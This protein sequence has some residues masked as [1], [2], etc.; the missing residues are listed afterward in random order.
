M[1][2]DRAIA[3]RFA[4]LVYQGIAGAGR[5]DFITN[6]DFDGDWVG[7]NNWA[8]AED[9]KYPLKGYVYWAL[10]E[11]ET[12]YFIFYA[13]FHPRDWKGGEKK[14][15]VLS[16]TIREVAT[17]GRHVDQPPGIIGDLVLSHEND[18]EGCVVAVAKGP[19]VETSHVVFLETVAHNRYL[20]FAPEPDTPETLKL[21]LEGNHPLIYIEPK[22][23]G[24]H[25]YSGQGEK[26]PVP[27]K[28]PAPIETEKKK[29]AEKDTSL[30]GKGKDAVTKIGGFFGKA[31]NVTKV[32]DLV[33]KK[34]EQESGKDD[35]EE[36]ENVLIYRFTGKAED[37]Q[38]ETGS[39]GYDLLPLYD[40]F[41]KH[42]QEGRS[43]AYGESQDYGVRSIAVK[44]SSTLVVIKKETIGRLGSALR[45]KAGA[46]NKA[47]PPWG[48]F[49][50]TDRKRPL[51]EWFLD[52]A[53]TILRHLGKAKDWSTAYIHN[54]FLRIFR[55]Q[56][57]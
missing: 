47:R 18:L 55:G 5:F 12:H 48:W 19:T 45:G 9:E 1:D 36:P 25:G 40:T 41:W 22:G 34:E 31:R 42:A 46:P 21:I 44:I 23:H 7:D 8:N 16:G 4:P 50:M 33:S 49:D 11:T 37:P 26:K 24:V 2:A 3:M 27:E 53:A 32:K 29:I 28:K 15:R 52:P 10:S 20:R 51:G 38:K 14:G 30:K 6:F 57:N 13:F 43:E 56:Q 54:P 39:I 17:L 35:T